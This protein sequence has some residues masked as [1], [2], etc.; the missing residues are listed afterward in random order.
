VDLRG[1]VWWHDTVWDTASLVPVPPP[2]GL[3]LDDS[4][5]EFDD[6]ISHLS[7]TISSHLTI[8]EWDTAVP[9]SSQVIYRVR[10]PS[11]PMTVTEPLSYSVYL[12]NVMRPIDP[13]VL[14]QHSPP[15]STPVTHHRV[16][17]TGLPGSP[18][19]IEL[20]AL[21]RRLGDEACVTSASEIIRAEWPAGGQAQS[22]PD[23]SREK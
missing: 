16:E 18:Y 21:S 4:L 6:L 20:M 8:V 11:T 15:D 1:G 2:S 10:S 14:S 3:L 5:P 23:P 13:S 22:R 9:A 17:L 12:P 19:T 7:V